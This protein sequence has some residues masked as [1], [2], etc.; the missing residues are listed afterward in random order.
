MK[1]RIY[2]ET[3]LNYENFDLFFVYELFEIECVH[4]SRYLPNFFYILEF[5]KLYI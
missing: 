3:E 2:V 4:S 5:C 1:L